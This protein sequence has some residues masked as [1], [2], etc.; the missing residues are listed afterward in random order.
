MWQAL[1]AELHAPEQA[2]LALQA[3]W[4]W[5]AAV[6]QYLQAP[7]RVVSWRDPELG[8]PAGVIKMGAAHCG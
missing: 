4:T 2:R 5:R 6:N 7:W 8:L 3:V 1:D